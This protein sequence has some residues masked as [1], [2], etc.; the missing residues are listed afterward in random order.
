M[1]EQKEDKKQLARGEELYAIAATLSLGRTG[2]GQNDKLA[3]KYLEKAAEAGC[4]PAIKRLA[5]W[6]DLGTGCKQ[7]EAKAEELYRRALALGDKSAVGSL[8]MLFYAKN[9]LADGVAL[10]L[11]NGIEDGAITY[12][13]FFAEHAFFVQ[14]DYARAYGFALTSAKHGSTKA[15]G[16]L[17]YC[18]ALG[19]GMPPNLDLAEYFLAQTFRGDYFC[20]GFDPLFEL[21]KAVV[22]LPEEKRSDRLMA[23]ALHSILFCEVTCSEGA[24][25]F[26]RANFPAG[27]DRLLDP[28][29]TDI[30]ADRRNRGIPE[31]EADKR[32]DK[33]IAELKG[34]PDP[35][36]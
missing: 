7:D 13:S 23:I 9:R 11:E 12:V 10:L 21:S 22:A 25:E 26:R 36:A 28:L 31:I 5:A 35:V 33:A 8:F 3:L 2:L 6:Y 17:A 20:D 29:M 16:I 15:F 14:R 34:V 30:L 1:K 19:A 32:V 27:S 4:L 18:L 24:K